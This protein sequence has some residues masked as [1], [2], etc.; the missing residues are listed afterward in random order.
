MK[1]LISIAAPAALLA[2]MAIAPANAG[3]TNLTGFVPEVCELSIA[4][5][6]LD[7][8]SLVAGTTASTDVE[9]NC[10]D[11]DG[12]TVTITSTESGMESDDNEDYEVDYTATLSAPGLTIA[13]L[14]T[15]AQGQGLD[16]FEVGQLAGPSATAS[17]VV[18][19]TLS[20]VLDEGAP[21]AGGYSDT[22]QIDIS[23]N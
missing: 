22:I 3:N 21:W 4:D 8:G 9:F 2:A 17:P 18:M 23:A 6:Q 15:G 5:A 7:F 13:P 16:H 10:N 19:G 11:G 20:I 12:A 1:K 14:D